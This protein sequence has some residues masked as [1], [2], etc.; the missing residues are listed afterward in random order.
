MVS[1]GYGSG[2]FALGHDEHAAGDLQRCR[3]GPHHEPQAIDRAVRPGARDEPIA[4]GGGAAVEV[5]MSY[6]S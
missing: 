2:R 5:A 4:A 6:M 1:P 3:G